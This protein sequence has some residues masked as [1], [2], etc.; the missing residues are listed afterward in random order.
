MSR[1]AAFIYSPEQ[2]AFVYGERHPFRP[3]RYQA[4][5]RLLDERELLP[6]PGTLRTPPRAA[7]REELVSWHD[8]GLVDALERADGGAFDPEML[9]HGIGRGECPVFPGV[10]RAASLSV[11]GTL[12][13]CEG[14]ADGRWQAAFAPAGGLHH[15]LVD[16]S[17]GFCYFNDVVLG[18]RL[19]T[20]RGLRVMVLDM[21]AHHGNGTQEAFYEDDRVMTVSFHETGETLYPWGGFQGERGRGQGEGWNVTVPLI[22]GTHP[23]ATLWGFSELGPPLMVRVRPDVVILIMGGD[24][25]AQDP[26]THLR[27]TNHLARPV[28]EAVTA[29]CPR[30]VMLGSGGYHEEAT[31]RY[32]TLAWAA[33]TGQQLESPFDGLVGGV[34]LGASE[35][36]GGDLLDMKVYAQGDEKTKVWSHLQAIVGEHQDALDL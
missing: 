12:A 24:V 36:Q 27:C 13:A 9:H 18:A 16:H 10:F 31:V 33:L 15:A 14:V 34:F 19:L 28:V 32:W 29:R 11:G 25:L 23:P 3:A 2:G 17:E 5:S 35:L 6:D 21:D 4:L 22:G 20:D 8:P 1:P 7:T 30:V 26:L